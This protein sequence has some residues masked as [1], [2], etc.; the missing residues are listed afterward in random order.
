MAWGSCGPACLDHLWGGMAWHSLTHPFLCA[1]TRKPQFPVQVCP[2]VLLTAY[3]TLGGISIKMLSQLIGWKSHL[4]LGSP[5]AQVSLASARRPA[6]WRRPRFEGNLLLGGL[7]SASPRSQAQ[8]TLS[9]DVSRLPSW[10]LGATSPHGMPF[11]QGCTDS[12]HKDRALVT[13]SPPKTHL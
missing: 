4:L 1:L 7:H 3:W 13:G 5:A 2:E 6:S 12:A 11:L 8:R 9:Y 10:H